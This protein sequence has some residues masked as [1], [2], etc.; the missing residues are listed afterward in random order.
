[1]PPITSTSKEVNGTNKE[2]L[3]VVQIM[4]ELMNALVE[5]DGKGRGNSRRE[6][7]QGRE[8]LKGDGSRN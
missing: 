4:R 1:M 5:L 6:R 8:R 2:V 3:R 7:K